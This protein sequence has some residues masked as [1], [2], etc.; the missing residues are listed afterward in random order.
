MPVTPSALREFDLF[1][2]GSERLLRTVSDATSRQVFQ[3]GHRLWLAGDLP[4]TAYFLVRGLVQVMRTLPNGEEATLGLFGPRECA[5][6]L[7]VLGTRQ[8]YPA[9]AFAASEVEVLCVPASVVIAA[10]EADAALAVA[11]NRVLAN[12]AQLLRAKIDVLT[13]GEIPQ[14]LATV[15]LH[16]ADRF[17][18]TSADG[19]IEVPV[20]LSRRSLCRLVG[21]REET[22]I[23]VMTRWAREG[24]VE[25]I[26]SGFL[27]R[28]TDALADVMHGRE[29][30]M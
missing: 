19:R 3:E 22:V 16:M 14:R 26:S 30:V 18:Q 24:L 17:G 29:A 27:L 15:L 2:G 8:A 12:H 21:A 11:A 25:T 4:H 7:A 10:V 1:R 23:R 6:I 5:G 28:S 20:V 13:A 9:D